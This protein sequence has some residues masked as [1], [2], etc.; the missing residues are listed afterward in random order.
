MR[1]GGPSPAGWRACNGPSS[2]ARSADRLDD[3]TIAGSNDGRVSP[4]MRETDL[5]AGLLNASL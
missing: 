4:A 1:S 2:S 5:I 3:R